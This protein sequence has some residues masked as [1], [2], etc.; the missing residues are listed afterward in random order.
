M[1]EDVITPFQPGFLQRVKRH[2][3]R[4]FSTTSGWPQQSYLEFQG[5]PGGICIDCQEFQGSTLQ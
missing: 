4:P 5:F 3:Q 2:R 1:D